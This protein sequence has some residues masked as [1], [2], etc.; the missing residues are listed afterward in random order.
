MREDTF[1]VM[2][3]AYFLPHEAAQRVAHH[4]RRTDRMGMPLSRYQRSKSSRSCSTRSGVGCMRLLGGRL[5]PLSSFYTHFQLSTTIRSASR[6]LPALAAALAARRVQSRRACERCL[7]PL[8]CAPSTLTAPIA[9]RWP[10]SA[11]ARPQLYLM[12]H[13]HLARRAARDCCIGSGCDSRIASMVRDSFHSSFQIASM[14][15]CAVTSQQSNR[16]DAYMSLIVGINRVTTAV[17]GAS[18]QFQLVKA[19]LGARPSAF[20]M[21]LGL[22]RPTSCRLAAA[23][24]GKAV[25][26][27]PIACAQRS[28]TAACWV[29]TLVSCTADYQPSI[30]K[31]STVSVTLLCRCHQKDR[32][33][34]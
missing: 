23:S 22:V 8:C 33:C 2:Y 1:V 14:P 12:A 3:A 32:S 29:A 7:H 15:S 34:R 25:K 31:C 27:H 4:P 6:L 24:A 19:F 10:R 21:A 5:R 17:R 26:M 20:L 11:S 28:A 16:I 13:H 9:A 18:E 30:Q